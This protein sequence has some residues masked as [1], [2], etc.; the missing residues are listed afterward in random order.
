MENDRQRS[1]S[2]RFDKNHSWS[3]IEAEVPDGYRVSYS[4][5][6]MTVS[7]TNTK[8]E[9]EEETTLPPDDTPEEETTKPDE[10]IDTGQLNWPIPVFTI[11]GL[12]LFSA[13]WAMLNLSRKDEDAA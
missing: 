1:H 8:I 12:L 2:H 6:Q 10:L 4:A 3:V 11:A 7:I 9:E 5:S 13:G